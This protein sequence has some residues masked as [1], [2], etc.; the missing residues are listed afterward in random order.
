MINLIIDF[1][2]GFGISH[3]TKLEEP[4][5][6]YFRICIVGVII[7][8]LLASC[9][10]LP[11]G[12]G[13]D[14]DST[15][16]AIAIQQTSLVM[17]QTQAAQSEQVEPEIEVQPTYT[18]YPTYTAQ[19][20]V[21]P[22]DV[23]PTATPE[24]AIVVEP[25]PTQE[26]VLTVSFEDWLEDVNILLYDD[27]FGAG[28]ALVIENA[29]DGLGLGDNTTN[30]RDAMGDFL[31]NMN[32]AVNWD[33]IIVAAES[34]DNIS[35]EYFDVIAD[36]IDRESSFI[37]EVWYIDDIIHGRIQPVFQR[38]GITFHRDWQ[39]AWNA[40]L[41]DYLVYL[42][43]PGD[44][45]FS[46]PNTISMLIPYDVLWWGDA[47]D[48]LELIPGSDAV[49]MA[50]AQSKEHSSYGLIA[51][52]MDGQMIWQTF[53]TH[54]Y[55]DQDMINLWQNYIYNTLRARYEKIN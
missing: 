26:I 27:M 3:I 11:T 17:Q 49:M 55:K 8:S 36:Q 37:F 45:L 6:Y 2:R 19:V 35:G 51:E 33:L 48:M 22:V 9:D 21:E 25:T 1:L 41:N 40:N 52:C 24:P 46:E 13:E 28:E 53:S 42:L 5:K 10:M 29:L 15:R 20:E 30:V 16:V 50:G 54:D 12:G 4:M 14:L 23:E 32:S 7:G 47:G 38:C 34:R 43:E 44:P 39:R 31:S 18:P